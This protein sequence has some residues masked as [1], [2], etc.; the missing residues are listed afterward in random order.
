LVSDAPSFRIGDE[1]FGPYKN[2]IVEL[3]TNAAVLL[4]CKER[5][6]LVKENV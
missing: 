3:S 2:Q 4:I 1:M 5:A 6:K